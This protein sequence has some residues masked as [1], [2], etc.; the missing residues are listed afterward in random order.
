MPSFPHMP[1]A[2]TMGYPKTEKSLYHLH[3]GYSN[4]AECP[5]DGDRPVR[6]NRRSGPD[7]AWR[8]GRCFSM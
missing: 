7:T 4:P 2:V 8:Q 1:P 3:G 6:V 5:P